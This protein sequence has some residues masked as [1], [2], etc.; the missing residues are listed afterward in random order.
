V[1]FVRTAST[2]TN[3]QTPLTDAWCICTSERNSIQDAIKISIYVIFFPPHSAHCA[4]RSKS[5][6]ISFLPR[7][8]LS[9]RMLFPVNLLPPILAVHFNSPHSQFS[10]QTFL[11]CNQYF[12]LTPSR[13][14]PSDFFANS[15]V[16]CFT[17]DI[18]MTSLSWANFLDPVSKVR[19]NT[20]S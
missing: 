20:Q 3:V 19:F 14:Q 17:L 18:D 10:D 11:W 8:S 15:F 7:P 13:S 1:S 9:V 12:P 4:D 5:S 2:Y 6:T 16:P